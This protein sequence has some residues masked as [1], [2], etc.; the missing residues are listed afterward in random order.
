MIS[1]LTPRSGAGAVTQP[2]VTVAT[3]FC[4]Q[5]RSSFVHFSGPQEHKRTTSAPSAPILLAGVEDQGGCICKDTQAKP[6]VS[7]EGTDKRE[8]SGKDWPARWPG[9]VPPGTF[10]LVEEIK[11]P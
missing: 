3:S 9:E 4:G 1:Q 11:S 2:R 7:T 8:R 5:G 10:P 6:G